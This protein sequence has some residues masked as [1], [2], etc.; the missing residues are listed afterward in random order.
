MSFNF[1]KETILPGSDSRSPY[2]VNVPNRDARPIDDLISYFKYWKHFI[3]SLIFYL[4]EIS[5]SKEFSANINYQLINSV[6]FP[7]FKDLPLKYISS[8]NNTNPQHGTANKELKKNL[9][10]SNLTNLGASP[11]GNGSNHGQPSNGGSSSDLTSPLQGE[12]RP[13]LLKSKSNN[14]TFMKRSGVAS[15]NN[16]QNSS[17]GLLTS[18]KRNTSSNGNMFKN[19]PSSLKDLNSALPFQLQLPNQL[20]LPSPPSSQFS[21]LALNTND[22][23]IPPEAFP[24]DSLFNNLPPLLMNHHFL[25]Y[26]T[27][28]KTHKELSH[29]LLPRLDTLLKNL[30]LKIKEI[31]SSLKNESFANDLV[32]VEISQTGKLLTTYNNSVERYSDP[33]PVIKKALDESEEDSAVL[34]DPFLLKLQVDH[35]LKNQLVQENYLFASYLNL[36]NISKD[37]LT[38]VLKELNFITERFTKLVNQESMYAS[39]DDIVMTTI[40]NHLQKN[41]QRSSQVHWEYFVENNRN[42]L[43]IYRDTPNS[44]KK[45]IRNLSKLKLPYSISIHNKCI[46]SG[47]IYKKLKILKNY[48]G[49]FYVLTCNYLH[50]FKIDNEHNNDEQKNHSSQ[51]QTQKK[52]AK[53]KIGGLIDYNDI[54]VKSYNLNDYVLK[55]REDK[56]F[57]FILQKVSNPG[58]KF[59]FKCKGL[60]DYTNWYNDLAELL[61]FGKDHL[62]RFKLVQDKMMCK[63]TEIK[64]QQEERNENRAALD[65]ANGSHGNSNVTPPKHQPP[66][67]D[68]SGKNE[69][70]QTNQHFESDYFAKPTFTNGSFVQSPNDSFGNNSAIQS[71]TIR[72]PTSGESRHLERNPFEGTFSNFPSN[73]SSPACS[74]NQIIMSN[75]AL[76]PPILSRTNSG[77][78]IVNHQQQHES[79]LQVQQEYLKQQQEILNLKIKQTELEQQ[80]HHTQQSLSP[81]LEFVSSPG[82]MNN[83]SRVSSNDSIVSLNAPS[84]IQQILQSN[85]DLLTNTP[86]YNLHRSTS[87]LDLGNQPSSS[88]EGIASPDVDGSRN[89]SNN[90]SDI[91]RVY[92]S[93]DH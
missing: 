35:Q 80:S 91:P 51:N 72:T 48:S 71:P 20:E 67:S 23:R 45:E 56:D 19:I 33:N 82:Q 60:N 65:A 87:S 70:P 2:Y 92:V 88:N 14:S 63:E 68:G 52:K 30:S 49:N 75:A 31:R 50:E 1:E 85:K 28:M 29:K 32:A 38:Y 42:F 27:Q 61:Q 64:R 66:N 89:S 83:H 25:S 76:S 40:L 18:H 37:L 86:S 24:Q 84:Q 9:S 15:G 36:Q 41:V 5:V 16:S 11:Q 69:N 78:Q 59:T 34:D 10:N 55:S 54:P 57:K 73:A 81:Q 46:R 39:A 13:G 53:D 21:N 43:N 62:A 22:M 12:K 8:I 79:Y 4:K 58:K 74:P 7:G 90:S 47:I 3:K 6:Q 93:S 44:S 26:Q 17:G 77:S